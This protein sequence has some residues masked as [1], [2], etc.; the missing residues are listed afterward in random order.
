[1]ES[2]FLHL[3]LLLDTKFLNLVIL[4]NLEEKA[5]AGNLSVATLFLLN[6]TKND[7]FVK[8]KQFYKHI[9]HNKFLLFFK[10]Y[11]LEVFI[12][13]QENE[14]NNEANKQDTQ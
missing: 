2:W 11:Y 9:L 5:T 1:M 8:R 13:R 10:N 6:L 12:S 7:V 14:Y 3:K 4:E